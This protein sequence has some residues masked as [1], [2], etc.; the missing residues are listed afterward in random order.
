MEQAIQPELS[1]P[2]NW[3]QYARDFYDLSKPGIGF[4]ALIT[5]AASFW[6][7]SSGTFDIPFF[8]KTMLATALVTCGGGALNQVIEVGP[9]SQMH[10]TEKRPLPSGRVPV[11]AGL[12]FGVATSIAGVV[13]MQTWVGSLAALLAIGTLVGYL[14]V[15]T[16]LKKKTSL[17]T[18]I[19]AFPGAI[20]ILIGWVAVTG[21]ID[22]RG[23]VLFAILFFWQIPHFLAIAWMYRKD[24]A[25]AGFPMLTVIDP[26]GF[27]AARQVIVYTMGLIPISLLPTMLGLTGWIY[28]WGALVLGVGFAASGVQTA[29]QRTNGAAKRLLFASIIYLPV[30][31]ALMVIDKL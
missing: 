27:R 5:T 24:Y 25:R 16:P 15:Y 14:F 17:S 7:A 4:Y 9:D 26:E 30:L 2:F 1:A 22:L 23:W 12:I 3:R 8:I 29:V 21:S 28:F 31:L 20:P 13:L 6:L 18:I 19:G 11:S 10:R